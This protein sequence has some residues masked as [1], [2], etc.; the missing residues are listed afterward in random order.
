MVFARI[1]YVWLAVVELELKPNLI[2]KF[3]TI[4]KMNV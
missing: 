2:L 1:I 4:E 3:Y